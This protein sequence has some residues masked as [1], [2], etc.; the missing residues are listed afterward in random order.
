MKVNSDNKLEN[1]LDKVK[2]SDPRKIPKHIAIIMDGNGRWGLTRRLSR[3]EGHNAS[4]DVIEETV[5]TCLDCGIKYLTLFCF[6]TENIDRPIF[7]V[8][9]LFQLFEKVIDTRVKALHAKQVRICISGNLEQLPD[10]LSA[11]FRWA[12]DFTKDNKALFLNLAVMY[13][14]REEILNAVRKVAI[15]VKSGILNP[16]SI[17][18]SSLR[19]YFYQPDIPDPDLMI[20]TS[21]EQRISNFMMWQLAYSELYFEECMWPEF[22]RDRLLNAILAY[23]QRVRRFGKVKI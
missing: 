22:N 4:I 5:N 11:K 21:G 6:S 2:K 10:S 12:A 7:E 9:T 18:D 15:D 1:L 8:L 16:D 3:V 23:Q 14:G 20:R 13:S 19:Q 17:N